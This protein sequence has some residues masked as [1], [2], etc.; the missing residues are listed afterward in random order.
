M[1]RSRALLSAVG[2]VVTTGIAAGQCHAEQPVNSP[3]YESLRQ[4]TKTHTWRTLLVDSERLVL[5]DFGLHEPTIVYQLQRGPSGYYEA[6]VE[7]GALSPDASRIVFSQK[8]DKLRKT[9]LDVLNI[10]N[11]SVNH[12]LKTGEIDGLAWSPDG[13]QIAY[14]DKVDRDAQLAMH[15]YDLRT[16]QSRVLLRENHYVITSQAWSPDGHQLVYGLSQEDGR[17]QTLMIYDL[18]SKTSRQLAASGKWATWSPNGDRIAY[19]VFDEK[20]I[21]SIHLIN[22]DGRREITLLQDTATGVNAIAS[23][24]L[25]SPDGAYLLYGRVHPQEP[26]GVRSHAFA[27]VTNREE[28]LPEEILWA[29]SFAG[30][31]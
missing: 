7:G 20:G 23:T 21:A 3:I 30:R 4:K 16:K 26:E 12:L 28:A 2:L 13:Q 31:K 15:V 5:F 25:W 11:R 17:V 29:H 19:L 1:I 9:D 24:A 27:L 14:V 6:D 18:V 8:D 10:S 22:P